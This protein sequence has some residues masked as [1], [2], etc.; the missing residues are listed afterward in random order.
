VL[1]VPAPV[2]LVAAFSESAINLEVRVWI[3]DP[4]NGVANVRSAV[5]LE[6]WDRLQ[7]EGIRFPFPQRDVHLIPPPGSEE[8]TS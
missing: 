5:L 6:V 4:A 1:A 3:N 2:C 8:K 7:A